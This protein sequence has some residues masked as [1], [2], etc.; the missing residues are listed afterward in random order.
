MNAQTKSNDYFAP[1]SWFSC[2]QDFR[3]TNSN[4]HQVW[5][6]K[7]NKYVFKIKAKILNHRLYVIIYLAAPN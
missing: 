5:L 2:S 4:T 1:K 6:S 3:N 7:V